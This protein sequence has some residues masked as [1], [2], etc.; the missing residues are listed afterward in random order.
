MEKLGDPWYLHLAYDWC[1]LLDCL[2]WSTGSHIHSKCGLVKN[3]IFK[4][5]HNISLISVAYS[6][7]VD[8][9]NHG[10]YCLT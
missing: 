7:V 6:F 5:M 10:C 4:E 3:I 2:Y 9:G 8:S 1:F